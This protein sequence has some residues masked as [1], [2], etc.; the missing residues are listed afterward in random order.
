MRVLLI[1]VPFYDYINIIR[2]AIS[3][4]LKCKVDVLITTKISNYVELAIDKV[5]SGNYGFRINRNNQK[6]FYERHIHFNYDFVFVIVGRGLDTELFQEFLKNQK[7]AVKILY[8]WDDIARIQNYATLS[9]LFDYIYSFDNYD[10][11]KYSLRFLPLFYC[12][13]YRYNHEKKE[14]S[15]YVSGGFH[16]GRTHIVEKIRKQENDNI[17]EKWDVRFVISRYERVRNWIMGTHINK[18]FIRYSGISVDEN[19]K[20]MKSSKFTID[21]PH[22]TQKG[23]SIRTFEALAS[24]TKL[25][26][27]QKSV[28]YYDFYDS[29]NICIINRQ[30]PEIPEGF[31]E[32]PYHPLPDEITDKYSLNNWLEVIFGKKGIMGA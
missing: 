18:E 28:K 6:A 2:T 16:S 30:N 8:L 24:Y 25:I 20:L 29:N 17:I 12:N 4:N 31:L 27:T 5:S 9:R 3:K 32:T 22:E 21:I 23:L 14:N 10:V 1:S 7:K 26:T 19:A 13:E 11:K 15:I